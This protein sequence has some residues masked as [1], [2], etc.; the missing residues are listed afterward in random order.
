[1][2]HYI[3]L[4]KWTDRGLQAVKD[5]P[6]RAE[7]AQKL[8]E[9]MGGSIQLFYT[10]GEYDIVG[11]TEAPDD[12]TALQILLQIGSQG[13]VRTTTLKAWTPEEAGKVIEKLQ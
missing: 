6:M 3:S 10:L 7:A 1:M 5:S 2:P 8:A 11:V 9:Q 13:N 12:E 4:I